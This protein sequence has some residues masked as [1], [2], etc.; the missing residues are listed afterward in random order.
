MIWDGH[1][2]AI[3]RDGGVPLN[4]L[5]LV[6][7][8]VSAGANLRD[9]QIKRTVHDL[10]RRLVH[11]IPQLRYIDDVTVATASKPAPQSKG[12]PVQNFLAALETQTDEEK[13]NSLVAA[14]D[15][16]LWSA[17]KDRLAIAE[18]LIRIDQKNPRAYAEASVAKLEIG[19]AH[20]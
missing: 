19:R 16:D 4:P 1:H 11:A 6:G 7:G 9:E 15:G 8:A 18:S 13:K 20:V 3:M 14:L 2:T 17:P 5:S 10:A 12:E